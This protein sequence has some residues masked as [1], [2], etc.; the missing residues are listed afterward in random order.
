[1]SED[2]TGLEAIAATYGR[3]YDEEQE[4]V[5][6]VQKHV[7]AGH[8]RLSLLRELRRSHRVLISQKAAKPHDPVGCLMTECLLPGGSLYEWATI[9][10]SIGTIGHMPL[11]DVSQ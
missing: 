10:A 4:M 6:W 9:G 7:E 1:M 3:L 8:D 2:Y 11:V 5:E